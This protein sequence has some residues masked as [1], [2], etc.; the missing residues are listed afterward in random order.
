LLQQPLVAERFH[1][2]VFLWVGDLPAVSGLG[3]QRRVVLGQVA[4]FLELRGEVG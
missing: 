3:L 4:P 2:H 1:V